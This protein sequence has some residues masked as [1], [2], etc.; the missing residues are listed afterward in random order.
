MP[1]SEHEQR[2][3]AQIERELN[4][5]DPRLASTLSGGDLRAQMRRRVLLGIVGGAI[6]LALLPLGIASKIPLASVAGFLIMLGSAQW[7]ISLTRRVPSA[8]QGRAAAAP[9]KV[10]PGRAPNGRKA[11]FLDRVEERRRRRRT[12]EG[13]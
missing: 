7:A 1:L 8:D 2:M 5:D 9:V 6:G 3:L 12:G 13:R 11:T 10:V 4:S